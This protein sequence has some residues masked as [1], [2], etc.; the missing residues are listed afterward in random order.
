MYTIW[1]IINLVLIIGINAFILTILKAK[2]EKEPLPR[3]F[4]V[5]LA[6]LITLW[7][8]SC[9]TFMAFINHF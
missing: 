1:Y 6:S 9:I 5:L 7:A 2:V 8:I 3:W 4:I